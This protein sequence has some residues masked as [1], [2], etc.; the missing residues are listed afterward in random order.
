VRHRSG[1]LDGDLAGNLAGNTGM[2]CGGRVPAGSIVWTGYPDLLGGGVL[3]L[4][5]RPA[6]PVA[7]ATSPPVTPVLKPKIEVKPD[8]V[9]EIPDA[10][11]G[12]IRPR[13]GEDVDPD[14][15]TFG[16]EIYDF[17]EQKPPVTRFDDF[18]RRLL[19]YSLVANEKDSRWPK[20]TTDDFPT[21]VSGSQEAIIENR[22]RGKLRP[23]FPVIYDG[24][25]HWSEAS[26]QLELDPDFS[27]NFVAAYL[28]I[29][30][31]QRPIVI[32]AQTYNP[33]GKL[34]CMR[35][36]F[37]D[38]EVVH[39]HLRLHVEACLKTIMA[40]MVEPRETWLWFSIARMRKTVVE[41]AKANEV[42]QRE[43][44][45]AAYIEEETNKARQAQEA[46]NRFVAL[47]AS[48]IP[49]TVPDGDAV[50]AKLAPP[51]LSG[52]KP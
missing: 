23:R 16:E 17:L 4:D 42:R 48:R 9:P 7:S 14:P 21:F 45:A 30:E 41:T 28:S 5:V 15:A 1:D 37:E 43:S 39:D 13:K 11:Y 31:A 52:E 20:P 24:Y 34:L 10:D 32:S 33:N 47:F 40:T 18:N 51:G 25:G 26:R 8:P 27:N 19:V 2:R 29:P 44:E 36:G 38:L 35:Y 22:V 3:P 50:I 6:S 12:N 46:Q 49:P